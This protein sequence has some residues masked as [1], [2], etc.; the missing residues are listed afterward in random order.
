MCCPR[1]RKQGSAFA[2]AQAVIPDFYTGWSSAFLLLL[3]LLMLMTVLPGEA[4][5]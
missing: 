5:L 3:P 1:G 2:G 4:V